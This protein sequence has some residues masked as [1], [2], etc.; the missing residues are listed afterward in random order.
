MPVEL[1]ENSTR[2]NDRETAAPHWCRI[3]TVKINGKPFLESRVF[4]RR[5]AGVSAAQTYTP[6]IR[7]MNTYFQATAWPR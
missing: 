5:R 7:P 1:V 4:G 2:A 3:A 6:T